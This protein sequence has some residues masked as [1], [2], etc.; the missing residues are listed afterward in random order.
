MPMT[1]DQYGNVAIDGEKS[2]E[3]Y[4]LLVRRS[5]LSL[6]IRTGL[7]PTRGVSILSICKRAYGLKGSKVQVL[8]Q[9]DEMLA[10]ATGD[11]LAPEDQREEHARES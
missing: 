3:V 5:A 6:W 9:M 7:Q 4:Q 2:V 10:R 1:T 8:A 11:G